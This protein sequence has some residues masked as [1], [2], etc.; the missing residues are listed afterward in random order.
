MSTTDQ[1]PEQLYA[2]REPIFPKR[3][4]GKF[5]SLKW[6]IMIVTLGIYYLTPWIRWDRGPQLPDQAVL[7][8]FLIHI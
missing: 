5:R 8:L 1:Q 3:V 4:K 6:I 7:I 2:A